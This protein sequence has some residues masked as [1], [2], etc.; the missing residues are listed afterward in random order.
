MLATAK[1]RRKRGNSKGHDQRCRRRPSCN[2]SRVE[3]ERR[4]KTLGFNGG[5]WHGTAAV[6]KSGVFVTPGLARIRAGRQPA[7]KATK[8][9]MFGQEV[10]VEAKPAKTAAKA[11]PTAALKD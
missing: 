7:T 9:L 4:H 11:F 6:K 3:E 8:R 1:G 2:Q 10:A 5:D